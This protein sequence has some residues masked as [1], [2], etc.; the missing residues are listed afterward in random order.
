MDQQSIAENITKTITDTLKDVAKTETVIGKPFQ[1]GDFQVVPVMKV[2]MGFGTGGGAGDSTKEGKG[3]GAGGGGGINIEPLAF[4]VAYGNEVDLLN[5][6]KGK[7]LEAIFECMPTV[8]G[9]AGQAIKGILKKDK[10]N[11][12]E[13]TCN[14]GNKFVAAEKTEKTEKK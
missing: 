8:I 11:H 3:S 4:L 2:S 10:D 6:G 9:E 5:L 1:L 14:P 12:E 13:C 7:G